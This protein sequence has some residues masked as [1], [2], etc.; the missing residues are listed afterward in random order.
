MVERPEESE[1][2]KDALVLVCG[3]HFDDFDT[4]QQSKGLGPCVDMSPPPGTC[5]FAGQIVKTVDKDKNVEIKFFHDNS[6]ICMSVDNIYRL[7]HLEDDLDPFWVYTVDTP[8]PHNLSKVRG[9][10]FEGINA[11]PPRKFS[12]RHAGNTPAIFRDGEHSMPFNISSSEEDVSEE[13]DTITPK[14]RKRKR[15]QVHNI[16]QTRTPT[17]RRRRSWFTESVYMVAQTRYKQA[18]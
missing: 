5:F 14:K 4:W 6:K 3:D 10:L 12:S 1:L 11:E 13:S 15:H 7:V 8:G 17:Q 18:T 16:Q 2:I 9:V